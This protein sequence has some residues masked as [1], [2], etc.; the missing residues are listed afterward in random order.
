MATEQIKKIIPYTVILLASVYFYF[1]AS[2]FGVVVRGGNLGPDFWPKLLLGLTMATCVYEIVKT[3]LSPPNKKLSGECV[4]EEAETPKQYPR[5]LI[6]GIV[7][8]VA[9]V[10][11]LSILGF[12][13]CTFLYL[14]LFMIVGRYRKIWVIAANSIIGT[15]L[16]VFL[17]MKVVYVS[18]P[19]GEGPFQQFSLMIF[20]ILG[21]K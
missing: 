9:Y 4:K 20:N 12:T 5:L 18:L 2:Q 16:F 3:A 19:I 14:T 7:M 17:F 8:T 21:I 1:L 11:F 10:Y 13:L 6:I 15:I